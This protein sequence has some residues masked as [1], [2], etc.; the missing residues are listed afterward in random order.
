MDALEC[1]ICQGNISLFVDHVEQ[2]YVFSKN[3]IS[4]LLKTFLLEGNFHILIK[5]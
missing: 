3:K 4:T 2:E 5:K 1:A